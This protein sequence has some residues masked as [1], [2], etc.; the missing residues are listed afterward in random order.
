MHFYSSFIIL[1][2][3]AQ[4]IISKTNIKFLLFQWT[5][6]L[7]SFA[8]KDPLNRYWVSY[9]TKTDKWSKGL[10]PIS[11][12]SWLWTLLWLLSK[13]SS[14]KFATV[15]TSKKFLK[16]SHSPKTS[17]WRFSWQFWCGWLPLCNY[18]L[19]KTQMGAC[20]SYRKKL[21][22]LLSLSANCTKCHHYYKLTSWLHDVDLLIKYTKE[23]LTVQYIL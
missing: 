1:L 3:V 10:F 6:W 11:M 9:D 8:K 22:S 21:L 12:A 15:T 18:S 14:C 2:S 16:A 5:T 7:I 4:S 20:S 23:S 17:N 19:F 13:F